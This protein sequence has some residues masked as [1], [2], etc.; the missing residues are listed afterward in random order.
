MFWIFSFSLAFLPFS[1]G[2][3]NFEVGIV[4]LTPYIVG[5]VLV[6]I[7][8]ALRWPFRPEAAFIG[9]HDVL[10]LLLA[11][12]YL[13]TTLLADDVV[14][15]GFLAFHSL[16]IPIMTYF[17]AK[18]AIMTERDYE[19][20][21]KFFVVSVFVFSIYFMTVLFAAEVRT[22]VLGVPPIGIA[23]LTASA[24][25][26][27]INVK[28]SRVICWMGFIIAAALLLTYSRA[29]ILSILFAPLVWLLV[30]RGYATAVV[31]SFLVAT[32][33]LTL[34]V[35]YSGETFRPASFDKTVEFSIERLTNIDFL[36]GTTYGRAQAYR[37]G[38][39]QFLS[40]PVFG[41]G[42][43]TGEYMVT[44]HNFHVE[45]L[46]YG[47][48]VGYLLY[49]ALLIM[50]AMRMAALARWDR[51]VAANFVVMLLVL[52][53]GIT[54]GLMHGV[55]P[56]MLFLLMGFNEARFRI[57]AKVKLSQGSG[58]NEDAEKDQDGFKTPHV[59]YASRSGSLLSERK[60]QNGE[61]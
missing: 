33:L 2:L 17:A 20:A 16:F 38:I 1:F 25:V 52:T 4:T 48:G 53:N 28:T 55:M 44:Q 34:A 27:A 45:W 57:D 8:A 9:R 59:I 18:A 10:M 46:E 21:Q 41:R 12:T 36:L 42:L 40:A 60:L 5:M 14:D 7:L 43:V 24:L 56:Y 37:S 3:A 23:T 13:A 61:R 58:Q 47:G 54:N 51:W 39:E 11:V 19:Y 50:H 26:I 6:V 15:A 30:R 49:A 31:S 32:L 22:K 29:Y 35:A